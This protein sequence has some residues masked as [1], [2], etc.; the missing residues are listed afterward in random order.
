[1]EQLKQADFIIEMRQ[2]WLKGFVFYSVFNFVSSVDPFSLN[3]ASFIS[4]LKKNGASNSVNASF[5][6]VWLKCKV[7]LAAKVTVFS[8]L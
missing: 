3:V 5:A 4:N 7:F 1:M 6:F 8:G 2:N